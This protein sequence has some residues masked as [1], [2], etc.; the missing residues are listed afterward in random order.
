MRQRHTGPC[1]AKRVLI[2]QGTVIGLLGLAMF[3]RELPGLV[4]EV[5]IWRMIGFGAG[6]RRP[7]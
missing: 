1:L 3:L 6:S 5:R 4:R 7:R 2:G